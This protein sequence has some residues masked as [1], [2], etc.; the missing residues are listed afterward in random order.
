MVFLVGSMW[1][2]TSWGGMFISHTFRLLFASWGFFA[3][4]TVIAIIMS[5]INF[6]LGVA[7][8]LSFGKN[9]KVLARYREQIVYFLYATLTL[10][11][12]PAVAV[13]QDEESP[14]EK[15]D[16]SEEFAYGE[17]VNFPASEVPT[18]DLVT[19][20]VSV[21]RLTI[22]VNAHTNPNSG[23][24]SPFS[25]RSSSP[26]PSENHPPYSRITRTHSSA[27]SKSPEQVS[28]S[29]GTRRGSPMN[30]KKTWVIE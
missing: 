22:P 20:H 23:D 2:I 19:K 15:R 28:G 6:T 5:G 29:A 17:K 11:A 16:Y 10:I 1:V 12:F 30:T 27:S 7:C 3:M 18:Y 8:R 13:H 4:L 24:R 21:P 25:S 26:T 14:I 9:S